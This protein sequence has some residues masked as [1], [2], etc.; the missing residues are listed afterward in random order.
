MAVKTKREREREFQKT[1]LVGVQKDNKTTH[2]KSVT[3]NNRNRNQQ[4]QRCTRTL[5]S[6]FAYSKLN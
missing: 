1:A 5:T 4:H 3:V 6:T 2:V